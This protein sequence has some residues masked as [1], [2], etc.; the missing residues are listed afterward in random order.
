MNLRS[1]AKEFNE[2][3]WKKKNNKNK[4][5]FNYV[6]F[7]YIFSLKFCFNAQKYD[8]KKNIEGEKNFYELIE[9]VFCWTR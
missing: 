9:F 1:F 5:F 4:I 6:K 7:V 3:S 8:L 2:W